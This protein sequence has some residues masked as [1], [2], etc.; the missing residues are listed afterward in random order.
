M[1]PSLSY[2][3]DRQQ[4]VS[5]R[6]SR[7]KSSRLKCG[8]PQVGTLAPI[9]FILLIN[10]IIHS[11][12]VFDFSIYADDTCLILGIEREQYNNTVN[13]E[14]QKIF[15]WFNSNDLLVNVTKTDYLHF[16]PNYRKKYIKG[17]YEMSELHNTVPL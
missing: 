3:K 17:E 14:I 4:F 11:S 1:V 2:L 12:N 9:L 6:N 15:N 7:S 16:G 8:V 5:I 13:S 10:D